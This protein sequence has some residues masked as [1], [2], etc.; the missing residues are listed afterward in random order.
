MGGG[1]GVR[2]ARASYLIL[3]AGESK[4]AFLLVMARCDS[5]KPTQGAIKGQSRARSRFMVRHK[6]GEEITRRFD[7]RLKPAICVAN[8]PSGSRVRRLKADRGG[9][10]LCLYAP[11]Y[12]ID[13]RPLGNDCQATAIRFED[14]VYHAHE[15]RRRDRI[16][17]NMSNVMCSPCLKGL[18]PQFRLEELPAKVRAI[19]G[20][21]VANI[22]SRRQHLKSEALSIR[23]I[24][25]ARS[26][27]ISANPIQ[28]LALRLRTRFRFFTCCLHRYIS[29]AGGGQS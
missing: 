24:L 12:F 9:L 23:T 27:E 3:F 15:R 11:I 18:R 25:R 2:G 10:A 13:S 17:Q 7:C 16:P 20:G 4:P 21:L 14:Q 22:T 1:G 28:T 19:Q 29:L 5:Q 26:L 6:T 8:G